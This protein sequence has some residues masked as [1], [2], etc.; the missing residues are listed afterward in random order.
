LSLCKRFRGGAGGADQTVAG[1]INRAMFGLEN[2]HKILFLIPLYLCIEILNGY[3][4]L[5]F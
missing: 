2:W 5:L 3:F 4:A 1:L